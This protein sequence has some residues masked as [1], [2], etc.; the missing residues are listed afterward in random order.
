M[1]AIIGNLKTFWERFKKENPNIQVSIPIIGGLS[2]NI[3][4][5]EKGKI[6]P[7]RQGI[8]NKDVNSP[9]IEE[10]THELISFYENYKNSKEYKFSHSPYAETIPLR[11]DNNGFEYGINVNEFK[12]KIINVSYRPPPLLEK[13]YHGAI[14]LFK[15]L[16]KIKWD[17][18]DNKW[19][20]DS[21]IGIID[22][23]I[24][25]KNIT[26]QPA[27]YFD[28]VGTNL[29]L[30]WAS[31]LL[32]D[33]P[34]S[35]I[36]NDFESHENYALPSLK[37][38]I[39]ANTLGVAVVIVNDKTKE[40]LIP[41]RGKE[42]GIMTDGKGKFHCS[43]SGVFS[44]DSFSVRDTKLTFDIFIKGMEK[45][46]E[47]EIGLKTEDY[48]LIPL[49]FTR[50]IVRGGKPQLFFI[51]KTNID[52]KNLNSTMEGAKDNWEFINKNNLPTNSPLHNFLDIPLKAP[53]EMFTYEG[54][55]ALK[56]ALAY[57]YNEEPPF[58]ILS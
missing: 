2:A 58:P 9:F 47:E 35:T 23:D 36:R 44:L 33:N 1:K 43:A 8:D 24:K 49:A 25:T 32:D 13:H 50:E 5:S 19:R 7:V 52:I 51:A 14:N 4:L 15:D 53:Q 54:W 31:G 20:N 17:K 45:E 34:L 38:S 42:Q 41:I 22:W 21:C 57:L 48:H 55:M 3:P 6:Y 26:I 12:I 18:K 40:V 29:S 28:Q 37:T 16:N 10:N 27:T 11:K 46:I 39:L 56:I 30:D